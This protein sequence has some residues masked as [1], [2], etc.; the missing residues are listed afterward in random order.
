MNNIASEINNGLG[1][2]KILYKLG[3]MALS[4]VR[5]RIVF[6][7]RVEKLAD[8]IFSSRINYGSVVTV[9]GVITRFGTTYR[10][11]TYAPYI[12]RQSKETKLGSKIDFKTGKIFNRCKQEMKLKPFQFPIQTLPKFE[13][14]TGKYCIAFIYPNSF[15]SFLLNEEKETDRRDSLLIEGKHRPIPVL[16]P[17]TALENYSES[18]I[19]LTGVISLLPDQVTQSFSR[20]ICKTRESFYYH[21]FRPYSTRMGFCIDCRLKENS[22][23]I[24]KRKLE[25]LPAAL[26]V[27]GHFEGVTEKKYQKEFKD[28]IPQ[29]LYWASAHGNNPG[30]THYF[31]KNET[32]STMGADPSIF[33]FY[34]EANLASQAD[35][36]FKIREL[37][38]FYTKFRKNAANKIRKNHGTEVRFKPDFIFDYKKQF[39]FHPDGVLSSKESNYTMNQNPENAQ[40]TSWLK[41]EK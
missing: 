35:M 27:E 12:P 13:D 41:Q 4:K 25:S 33:G 36:D 38:I 10:P 24:Q 39:I 9:E 20:T 30:V 28:S 31:S 16:I 11:L 18:Q 23:F 8:D 2:F 17:E 26:Y 19:K 34:I 29:G 32:I 1:A 5:S 40:T 7:Y 37:E 3:N 14:E 6:P 15:T 22:D 21:F